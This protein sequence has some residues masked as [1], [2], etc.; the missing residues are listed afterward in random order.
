MRPRLFERWPGKADWKLGLIVGCSVA[1]HLISSTETSAAEPARRSPSEVLVVYNADSPIS[2]SV[3]FAYTRLRHVAAMVPVHCQDAAADTKDETI[4]YEAYQKLIEKPV[5]DYLAAHNA[6][7]FVVLTKGV[8]L[9]TFGAPTGSRNVNCDDGSPLWSSVDSQLAALGYD[10]IAGAKK[11]EITG[12]GATGRSW[13]NRYYLAD[14]PF[15]HAK[16]GGYLVSRLDG[17]TVGDAENLAVRARQAEHALTCGE[18][19]LDVQGD[20]GL[21]DKTAPPPKIPTDLTIT[22]E[23]DWSTYNAD[24][25]RAHDLLDRRGIPNELNSTPAFVGDRH[26]LLGYFSWGSND[27]HFSDEAYQSLT[28]AAGSIGDTAVS[29][30]A[31]TFLP[32]SGGQSLLVDLIAHGLTC[33]KG[34]TDEPLLQAMASPT[35]VLERYTSGYTMAESFYMA[36]RFVGWEDVVIGDPLCC[37][38]QGGFA[39]K[40]P[41]PK[42]AKP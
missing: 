41:L 6:I 17:Y 7:N 14:E 27:S 39:G 18:V 3:A 10:R 34:Y 30:S 35:I 33:G 22:S 40:I 28:F 23:L 16:F 42:S 20:Y 8:P 1:L 29:T 21:G 26:N 31:R 32:T 11:L 25:E 2:R 9:R 13:L 37:P 12:A 15:S 38:F 5:A 19:L 4:A 36:S 24:L